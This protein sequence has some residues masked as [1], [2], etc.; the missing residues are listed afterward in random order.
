MQVARQGDVILLNMPGNVT[1]ATDS[2]NIQP[3]FYGTLN[4]VA[5]TLK[6]YPQTLINVAGHTDSTGSAQHNQRLS[7]E[8][9]LSVAQ[10]LAGQGVQPERI[11]VRGYG[12]TRPIA[13]NQTAQGRQANRRVE[14]EI[15]PFT[16]Q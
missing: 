4:Q 15:R 12:F 6:Q 16:G 5:N 7:E 1:F 3:Q 9:A 11:M 2:A 14:I 10:F 13:T 8:R